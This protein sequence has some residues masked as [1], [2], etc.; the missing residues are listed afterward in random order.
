MTGQ[1]KCE[2]GLTRKN[3]LA[4]RLTVICGVVSQVEPTS[5]DANIYCLSLRLVCKNEH[6]DVVFSSSYLLFVEIV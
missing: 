6:H 5:Y 3:R 1:T 2:S 4:T